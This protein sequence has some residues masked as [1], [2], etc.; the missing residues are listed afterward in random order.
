MGPTLQAG[1]Y[2]VEG[3][4]YKVLVVDQFSAITRGSVWGD[5]E[6]GINYEDFG[7]ADSSLVTVTGINNYNVELSFTVDTAV[8]KQLGIVTHSGDK[9]FL[10]TGKG[11]LEFE[12][13]SGE[14][15]EAVLEEGDPISAPP[16]FYK[17]QPENQGRLL[18]FTGKP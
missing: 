13:I 12:K 10:K 8:Y 6:V 1:Y 16:T 17:I 7:A 18:L 11:F 5:T 3:A 2:K 9:L 14:E 15:A 4:V